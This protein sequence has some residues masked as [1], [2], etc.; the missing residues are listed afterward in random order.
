MNQLI[1]LKPLRNRCKEVIVATLLLASVPIS[2]QTDQ[3]LQGRI[4]DRSGNPISGAIINIAEDSRIVISDKNGFFKLKQVK[5]LD[6]INISSVGYK[7]ETVEASFIENLVITLDADSDI[8][9]K[10]FAMPFSSVQSKHVLASASTVYGEELVKH[11]VTVLQNAF[12][13]NVT[14]VPTYEANSEPGWSETEIYIR[15]LRT[16][17]PS[18]RAPLVIVD[19]IERDL[20]FLDAF[21]IESITILKDA[22]ATS[23]YGM[24]GANGVILVTTRRGEI[25]KTKI[26]FTQE[27]GYQTISG[28][29]ESQNSYNYAYTVNQARY[30]DG[31]QPMYTPQDLQ[32]YYEV[33]KGTL[34]P[35]LRYKYF[36]TNWH[37]ELLRDLAPQNRTNLTVSGGNKHARYYVALSYLRQEGMYDTKWTELN[38][39]YST[40]HALN[41]FNLRS[42][43]DIDVTKYLNVSLDL[44]GRLDNI[45]QPAATT[46]DLFCW[47]SGELLPTNP[48]FT[49]NGEFFFPSDNDA[50]NGVARLAYSGIAKNRRRNLY[51]NVTATGKLD[52]ITPGLAVK[53]VA[54]FDSYT[55][56]MQVQTQDS[57][58]FFY[59]FNSGTPDDVNSYTYIRKRTAAPLS[60]PSEVP[61]EMYYNIN[62]IGSLNYDRTFGQHDVSAQAMIRTYQNVVEGFSSSRRFLT[63]GM[64]ANYTYK[65]RYMAQFAASMQGTD[66]LAP[67]DRFGFFP[68]GSIGWL[69]SEEDWLKNSNIQLLKLRASLGRSGYYFPT[70]TRYPYEGK[71]EHG[72][73]YNFGTSQSAFPGVFESYSGNKNIKW[74]LSDMLNVGADFDLWNRGLYGQ[75][76]VFKEWRS[77]ILVSRSTI[78]DMYGV[79]VPQDSYGKAETKG[80]EVVLGHTG[81]IGQVSYLVEGNVSYYKNKIVEMD[82]ITPA[83][84]YQSKTGRHIPYQDVRVTS[85]GTLRYEW[86]Q[87]ASDESLIAT[88]HQ[89]AIDNPDKYPYQGN[90]KLGNAIFVDANGDRVIDDFD[91][92]YYK[93]TRIPELTPSIKLGLAWKGFDGRVV[94][95]AYLNRTVECRENMDYAGGWGG[96]ST[97]EVVNTWGYFTDDPTDPRNINAKYPRLS[98]SFSDNDR[99]YP[100]NASSIWLQN[101]NFFSFRNIE[102]GYSL[103]K[104][105]IAKA[106]MTQ[107]RFYFSGYNLF[108]WSHFENGFDPENPLNYLWSYPKTKSFSFGVN[109]GF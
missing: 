66:D 19:N 82:E 106:F 88:S 4:V 10:S 39:G 109:V 54:G 71:Y 24:R 94:L 27:I 32:H 48:I 99:N 98:G 56:Y 85:D 78:P 7:N 8:Y 3:P 70:G 50:K 22:A 83:Y 68:G 41:R 92:V 55:T 80:F 42:N 46:W 57:N 53:A 72:G 47:G 17:N 69:L 102:V 84:D 18:F 64:M 38:E 15:G 30:L 86:V 67:G 105:F 81:K 63:Y 2:A 29:P 5:P 77:N 49:P 73:G 6:E 79:I 1:Y 28:I 61:R 74:E 58:G 91:K 103:P 36:N 93:Y 31:N 26:N 16:M 104:K 35:S 40:Q 43:I 33:S 44:G 62:L 11:P 97:H 23:I 87:W 65:N 90:I 108:T 76:D 25:G 95:T 34:D 9:S 59:D 21:P 89:D 60:N 100:R 101:G 20:S 45:S 75:V 13:G 96:T 12:A 37:D 51:S 107:C 14:G 52:K